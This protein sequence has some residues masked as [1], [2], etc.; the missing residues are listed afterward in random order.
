MFN[1]LSLVAVSSLIIALGMGETAIGAQFISSVVAD[2]LDNPR[3]LAFG[4]DGALYVTESGLGGTGASIVLSDGETVQY[5]ST[6]AIT[7]IQNGQQ[8]RI[9]TGL[10]SLAPSNGEGSVGPSSIAFDSNGK[11]YVITGLGANPDP[12]YFDPLTFPDFGKLLE[13]DFNTNSWT[14]VADLGA[15]EAANNP[16]GSDLNSNPYGLLI[17]NDIAYVTD[18]GG[19]DLLQV[20]TDGSN[21]SVRAVF[22]SSLGTNPFTGQTIP[23][24]SVPT[25]ITAAGSGELF[26]GQLTGFPFT[27]GAANVYKISAGLPPEIYAGGFTAI[28][29]LAFDPQGSLY[30]LQFASEGI[31]SGNGALIKIDPDGTRTTIA[32]DGLIAP[33]GL[34][35]GTDGSIYVSNKSVL[36]GQGEVL[37]FVAQ[38]VPD[39]SSPMLGLIA[40]GA[41]S[42]VSQIRKNKFN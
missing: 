9:I 13:V 24:Q 30:V 40:L 7:K 4:L 28:T 18:A 11:A 25:A 38:P 27:P 20:N 15:F 3:G 10:P 29:G 22:P 1:K 41:I 37:K 14:T 19:N 17:Q 31:L 39:N 35:I 33:T 34:A 8:T 21:L 23:V 36:P 26:V 42:A 6:G 32:S 2:G 12:S 5:G 16:D